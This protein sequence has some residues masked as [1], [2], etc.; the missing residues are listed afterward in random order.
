MDQKGCGYPDISYH[1]I[2]AWRPDLSYI[3]RMAG[4][5]LCGQYVDEK[6]ASFYIAFNMHWEPHKFALPKLPKG[7]AWKWILDTSMPLQEETAVSDKNCKTDALIEI[8]G[9]S[10]AIYQSVPYTLPK[11][12]KIKKKIISEK[13]NEH[14]GLETF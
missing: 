4:I 5:M 14:E 11:Q 1:G 6:A 10:I 8:G 13:E 2:E 3:S 9:R 7:S 12:S